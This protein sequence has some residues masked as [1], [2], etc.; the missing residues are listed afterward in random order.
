MS[1]REPSQRRS[2]V[3]DGLLIAY[4]F[5][6]PC[7]QISLLEVWV[8]FNLIYRRPDGRPGI[9]KRQFPVSHCQCLGTCYSRFHQVFD[10]RS[11]E[12]A[13]SY[14][15]NFAFLDQFLHGSPCLTYWHIYY[16]DMTIGTQWLYCF[17]GLSER[18]WPMDLYLFVQCHH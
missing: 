14:G 11:R 1:L 18:N 5:L 6:A 4:L 8:C 15:S 9:R 16:V 7:Q 12:I 13:D 2:H 17:V 10:S 3:G